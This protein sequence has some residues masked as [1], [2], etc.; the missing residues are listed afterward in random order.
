M[1]ADFESRDAQLRARLLAIDGSAHGEEQLKCDVV[2]RTPSLLAPFPFLVSNEWEPIPGWPQGGKG[3]LVFTDGGGRY[4]VVEVKWMA[5]LYSG[6]SQKKRRNKKR[7]K[8][9]RQAQIYAIHVLQV[10][11][12]A[13]EV[14]MMTYTNDPQRPGLHDLGALARPSTAD[15]V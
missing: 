2:L 8:V 3:D 12:D 10:C 11:T 4:A 14:R 9:K 13:L 15:A 7:G 5:P 6:P 1:M